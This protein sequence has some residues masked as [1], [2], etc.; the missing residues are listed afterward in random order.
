MTP[1]KCQITKP[2]AK[3]GHGVCQRKIQGHKRE[4][5]SAFVEARTTGMG[6]GRKWT[7]L[8]VLKEGGAE[9]KLITAD[10]SGFGDS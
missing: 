4:V 10:K 7:H 6:V 8:R 9:W 5:A 1:V 2:V 3:V